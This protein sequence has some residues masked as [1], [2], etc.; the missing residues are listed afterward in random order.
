MSDSAPLAESYHP[1][2]FK[3]A[4]YHNCLLNNSIKLSERNLWLDCKPGEA[5]FGSGIGDRR[6]DVCSGLSSS[7]FFSLG[8][9]FSFCGSPL[10]PTFYRRVLNAE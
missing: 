9:F 5:V 3:T 8:F 4:G 2:I 7:L 6:V 10:R 1:I